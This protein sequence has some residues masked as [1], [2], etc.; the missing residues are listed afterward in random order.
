MDVTIQPKTW[1]EAELL[2]L[3]DQGKKVELVRGEIV[4][5]PAGIDH[6]EIGASLL[7][8]LKPFA[9]KNRLGIVLGSSAGYWMNSGNLRSPDV[10]FIARERLQGLKRPPKGFFKGSPDLA[11]EILSPEDT[12]EKLHEKIVEYFESGAKLVWVINPE[13]MI[14]LVYHSPQP[15]KLLRTG[16]QLE[17][18]TVLP[19]FS[20][21]VSE[22]FEELDF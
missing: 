18:E 8:A 12:V 5:G 13:E 19:D 20:F 16:E 1:T 2:L 17:G 9:R 14:V 21:P 11:V 10:S 15:D 3:P 22:L 6:E 7:A 4:M